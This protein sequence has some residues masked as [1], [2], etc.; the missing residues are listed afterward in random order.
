M[1][2]MIEKSGL[3]FF[4][5]L[6]AL[7]FAGVRCVICGMDVK[8]G[9]K[10]QFTVVE[11]QEE[12][13]FCSLACVDS[14]LKRKPTREVYVFDYGSGEK[15]PASDAVFIAR[16]EKLLKELEF[17]MPPTVIGFT[18][19]E[20]AEKHQKRLGDGKLIQGFEALRKEFR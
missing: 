8:P 12:R 20:D 19:K 10:T 11:S 3:L 13:R 9:S 17:E 16:S 18:N 5:L 15:I 6:T 7:S 4:A 14:Y 2:K 1:L